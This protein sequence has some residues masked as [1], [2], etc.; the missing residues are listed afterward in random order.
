MKR[1]EDKIKEIEKRDKSSRIIY[2]SFVLVIIVF[3]AIVFFT[4]KKVKA[5]EQVIN[6]QGEIIEMTGQEL[7]DKTVEL[8]ETIKRLE[9]SQTPTEFWEET[10][11]HGTTQSYLDYITYN[12][13][14]PKV[15]FRKEALDQVV[16]KLTDEKVGWLYI[17]KKNGDVMTKGKTNVVWRKDVEN[18]NNNEVPKV[19]DIIKYKGGVAASSTYK[20]F[21]R[22]KRS[23]GAKVTWNTS[24][25]A[26]VLE[27]R[28]DGDAVY[29]KIKFESVA[30]RD[31]N[32]NLRNKT[33]QSPICEINSHISTT[34]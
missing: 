2:A 12:R 31:K 20:G 17:G 19:N 7:Y 8:E 28:V 32:H 30:N 11:V 18:V 13:E 25:K 23:A 26:I 6:E 4:D 1:I 34:I 22:A 33:I 29:I 14:T 21:G 5:Q 3:M 24:A 9:E 16:E 27:K 10:K 15:N